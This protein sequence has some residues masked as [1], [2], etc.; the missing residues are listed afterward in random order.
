MDQKAFKNLFSSVNL[1]DLESA[2]FKDSSVDK[3]LHC[4]V[5]L[6]TKHYYLQET[7]NFVY[8]M[9]KIQ[10]GKRTNK[11]KEL[12]K[13]LAK[14]ISGTNVSEWTVLFFKD[15]VDM[16]DVQRTLTTNG[17][18]RIYRAK[19]YEFCTD[20]PT[21]LYRFERPGYPTIHSISRVPDARISKVFGN[22]LN[23]VNTIINAYY[24]NK[25]PYEVV[26]NPKTNTGVIR[27]INKLEKA[28]QHAHHGEY[29]CTP[30][31][32]SHDHK[33]IRS[34][35]RFEDEKAFYRFVET[36]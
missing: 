14:Y 30:V 7:G 25:F 29:T 20:T 22:A 19:P 26:G 34:Q 31:M 4:L 18:T 16:D 15:Y 10:G 8:Q 2:I 11:F 6:P 35:C 9:R 28:T 24:D 12:S 27:Y 17:F 1:A 21:T 33:M 3:N 5:H 36:N 13:T 23:K 32:S